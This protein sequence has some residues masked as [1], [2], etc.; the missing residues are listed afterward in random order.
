M[1]KEYDFDKDLGFG[2]IDVHTR[3]IEKKE[4]VVSAILKALEIVDLDRLYVD[5]DCGMKLLPRDIAFQKLKVMVEA[6]K[7]VEKMF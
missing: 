4:E 3:R 5:P 7:E 2:C 1:L 6:T